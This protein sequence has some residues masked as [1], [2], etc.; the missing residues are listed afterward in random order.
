MT[1]KTTSWIGLGLLAAAL[2]GCASSADRRLDREE[3]Q[4]DRQERRIQLEERRQQMERPME[5]PY[6][7]DDDGLDAEINANDN[8]DA[9]DCERDMARPG[10]PYAGY[11]DH[12]EAMSACLNERARARRL[13]D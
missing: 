4:L 10:S 1:M 8:R 5:Q 12:D 13:A 11:D 7:R 3:R 9:R 2:A 6:G